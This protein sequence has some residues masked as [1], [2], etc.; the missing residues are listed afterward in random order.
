MTVAY[1][2]PLPAPDLTPGIPVPESVR[3]MTSSPQSVE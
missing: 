1:G 2:A 3:A